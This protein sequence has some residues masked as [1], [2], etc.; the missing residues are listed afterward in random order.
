Q[1]RVDRDDVRLCQQLVERDAAAAA[2]GENAPLET[3]GAPGDGATE[4][5]HG[6]ARATPSADPP[7]PA[8]PDVPPSRFLGQEAAGPRAG[9]V[10]RTHAPV[11]LDDPPP[12]REDQRPGQV[13]GQRREYARPV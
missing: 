8:D 3:L 7:E 5:A 12:R 9:P 2:C 13:F 6:G 11:A 10:A 4:P 1:R